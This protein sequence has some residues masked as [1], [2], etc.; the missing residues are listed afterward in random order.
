MASAWGTYFVHNGPLA[1]LT[2][3]TGVRYIGSSYGDNKESF[4]VPHN[5]MYDM[6]VSY[7]L[8]STSSQWKGAVLQIC[9]VADQCQQPDR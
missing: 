5:I 3:E 7:D 8:G 1:G 2:V 9:G 6:M 4:S